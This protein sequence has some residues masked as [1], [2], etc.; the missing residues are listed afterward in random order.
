MTDYLWG[1]LAPLGGWMWNVERRIIKLES[2]RET[3]EK[4]DVKVDKIVDHL[5]GTNESKK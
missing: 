4:V 1:L 5:I 2:M 3:V